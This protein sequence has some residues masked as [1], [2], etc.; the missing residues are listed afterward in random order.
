MG[1]GPKSATPLLELM[2][3][4]VSALTRCPGELRD[5]VF[6]G[7][8]YVAPAEHRDPDVFRFLSHSAALAQLVVPDPGGRFPWEPG[9]D[10]TFVRTQRL[11]FNPR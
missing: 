1:I 9:C 7:S 3:T 11:L 5:E 10:E 2:A 6:H 8:Y 4:L